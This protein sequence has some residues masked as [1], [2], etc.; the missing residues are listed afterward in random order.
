MYL[1]QWIAENGGRGKLARQIK[2]SPITIHFWLLKGITPR[3]ETMMR[4]VS[5]TKGQVS[6]EEI[7]RE[8]A[9]PNKKVRR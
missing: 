9:K 5:L 8:T 3:V 4:I 6:F 7:I 2:V 1:S